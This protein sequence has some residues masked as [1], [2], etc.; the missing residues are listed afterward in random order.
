MM[1]VSARQFQE[2][3]LATRDLTLAIATF[4]WTRLPYARYDRFNPFLV[5]DLD[6][7]FGHPGYMVDSS[8]TP[9][10]HPMNM[11]SSAAPL[12]VA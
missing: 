4:I 1:D 9:M 10:H 11:G 8:V 12:A 3:R 7:P 5:S 6:R 2:P